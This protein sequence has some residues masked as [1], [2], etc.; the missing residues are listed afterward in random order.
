[1]KPTGDLF[2]ISKST[3]K[4]DSSHFFP[5]F[6]SCESFFFNTISWSHFFIHSPSIFSQ[7]IIGLLSKGSRLHN[8]LNA[9]NL[10]NKSKH[11]TN[12]W[13]VW[14]E[15]LMHFVHIYNQY[16]AS[17]RVYNWSISSMKKISVFHLI[18]IMD[19]KNKWKQREKKEFILSIFCFVK[20]GGSNKNLPWSV[21]NKKT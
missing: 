1:M 10:K 17:N 4:V 3:M 8:K 7:F 2:R 19:F 13:C 6:L 20:K 9:I 21:E 14:S 12:N 15:K 11:L 5:L 16:V 18:Y